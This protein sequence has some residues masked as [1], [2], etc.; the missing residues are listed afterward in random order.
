MFEVG[1]CR[2]YSTCLSS[3]TLHPSLPCSG[4]RKFTHIL[5]SVESLPSGS[6]WILNK[7]LQL[8]IGEG[9]RMRCDLPAPC[10]PSCGITLGFCVPELKVTAVLNCP[11]LHSSLPGPGATPCPLIPNLEVVAGAESLALRGSPTPQKN[12]Y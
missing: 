6:S 10:L 3:S 8:E 11:C 5:A 1:L 4:P 9:R 2:T 7:K 12:N